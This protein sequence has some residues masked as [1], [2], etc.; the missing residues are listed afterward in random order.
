M[1]YQPFFVYGF[2]VVILLYS[3]YIMFTDKFSLAK[4]IKSFQYAF[5][6]LGILI[7][8]EHNARIHLV[9]AIGVVIAGI[10]CKISKTE[11]IAIVFA[12]G[13]VICMEIINSA[14]ENIADFICPEQHDTIKK[15]KD[16]AA[17]GVLISAIV[18]LIVGLIVFLPKVI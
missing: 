13:L 15:V 4:R 14:I 8:E 10:L 18:A 16:L 9:A 6:G 7:K 2:V 3:I 11:W 5:N 17:A 12:I 1:L